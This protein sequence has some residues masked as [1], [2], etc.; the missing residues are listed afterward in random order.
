ML[1][2][3]LALP[4][5]GCGGGGEGLLT[6]RQA[7]RLRAELEDARRAID[8][9]PQRCGQARDAAQR[10]AER[11]AALPARVDRELQRNLREGFNHLADQVNAECGADR[12]PRKTR[13]P[14]PTP[15]PTVTAEPTPTPTVTAEPTPTPTETAEPTPTPTET[16]VPTV[17]PD[18]GGTDDGG[19]TIAPGN[20]EDSNAGGN[21]VRQVGEQG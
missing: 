19:G 15:T 21:G 6:D 10:G 17:T 3:A 16:A 4:V 18:T 8:E 20:S 1:L 2:A 11:V 9:S 5:A 13:T 7:S 12:E 14:E